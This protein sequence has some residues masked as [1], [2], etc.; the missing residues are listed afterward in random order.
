MPRPHLTF[1]L[2]ETELAELNKFYQECC[3]RLPRSIRAVRRAQALRNLHEGMTISQVLKH[4][5]YYFSERS[6]RAWISAYRRYGLK[7]IMNRPRP[8]VRLTT[9]QIYR[10]WEIRLPPKE[11]RRRQLRSRKHPRRSFPKLARWVAEHWDIKVSPKRLSLM[12]YQVLPG[13][14]TTRRTK[15]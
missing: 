7:G 1:R 13:G 11:G 15:P 9:A 4:S 6:L 2:S 12:M 3:L 14:L 10:L 8:G 5:N